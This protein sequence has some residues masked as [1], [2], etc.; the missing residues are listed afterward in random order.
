MGCRIAGVSVDPPERLRA[1]EAQFKLSFPLLSDQSRSGLAAWG[2]LNPALGG[3]A[4][5]AVCVAGP[6]ARLE[7]MVRETERQRL[8]PESLIGWLR[9][10]RQAQLS[11]CRP[12]LADFGRGAANILK[13]GLRA[14]A[15]AAA[16]RRG[17][18]EPARRALHGEFG[19]CSSGFAAGSATVEQ[20]SLA[21]S[22]GMGERLKPAVLKTAVRETV[23]GVRIPLPPPNA[24][25]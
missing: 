13:Y 24:Q 21:H 16:S 14:V 20:G 18:V 9:E 22:G 10:Q 23:P 1:V 6:D 7:L 15:G 11:A 3:I 25:P 5:P 8:A 19:I 12:R 17:S 2:L 4:H